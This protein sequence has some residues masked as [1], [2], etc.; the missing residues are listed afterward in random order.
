MLPSLPARP[1]LVTFGSV[2]RPDGGLQ[3]RAR[4]LAE[5]LAA[6]GIPPAIVST[7]EPDRRAPLPVWARSFH[8]PVH[9]PTKGFSMEFSRLI[10]EVAA[11]SDVVFIANAMFMPALAVSRVSL[12][13]IWDTNECQSLHYSRLPRTPRNRAKELVWTGL[14]RWGAR[15][16]RLAVSIGDPEAR[17]WRSRYPALR[18]KIFTVDHVPFAHAVPP[19][20]ARAEVARLA[21]VALDGPILVFVGTLAAKHNLTAAQWIV[22][23][24]GPSLPEAVTVLLCGPG[25]DRFHASGRG[26]SV[27]GL[28]MV[29]DV[30]SVVA[31]ADLCLAPLA[32]GAGVKTKV[33][34]YL[35]HGRRVAGTPVAFEGLENAPGMFSASLDDLPEL[36]RRL[37]A[38]P[39]PEPEAELRVAAQRAW[40]VDH[41]AQAQAVRQ[42]REA[43]GC[44]SLN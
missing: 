28:G 43:L 31:S 41:H 2:Q 22:D 27:V 18:R 14:E 26:A 33:L 16:C 17:E 11:D 20:A 1:M 8:I 44:L 25:S 3:V 21:G 36:V 6:L 4:V 7:R 40:M 29:E 13:M 32:S 23:V 35:V 37:I 24:L 39:E 30:D 12:P 9:K 38:T 5:S 10:R 34:H 42:W 19:A 15:R